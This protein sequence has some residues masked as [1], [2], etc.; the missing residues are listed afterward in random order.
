[1]KRH[2]YF[3]SWS[4]VG[5][6]AAGVGQMAT[7]GS[8][9]PGVIAVGVPSV[10]IVLVGGLLIHRQVPGALLALP[11]RDARRDEHPQPASSVCG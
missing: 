6:V 2:A 3:M 8:D 4:Y 11:A 5:L 1:M 10:V 9:L 7:G